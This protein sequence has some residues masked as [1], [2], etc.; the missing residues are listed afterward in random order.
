MYRVNIEKGNMVELQRFFELVKDMARVPAVNITQ[1]HKSSPVI[2]LIFL[3]DENSP[4]NVD[5][6]IRNDDGQ[7]EPYDLNAPALC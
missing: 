2:K 5:T 6:L 1:P 3:G 4:A 7:L